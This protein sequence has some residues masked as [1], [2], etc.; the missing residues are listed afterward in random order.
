MSGLKIGNGVLQK[1]LVGK[2]AKSVTIPGDVE[3]VK[4]DAFDGYDN[5]RIVVPKL[6]ESELTWSVERCLC[7]RVEDH[8][9]WTKPY[10]EYEEGK[11][12]LAVW[13]VEPNM[14]ESAIHNAIK[15]EDCG[16]KDID[17][18]L[19]EVDADDVNKICEG[20]QAIG[21]GNLVDM[22]GDRVQTFK[23][24]PLIERTP[25]RQIGENSE[26]VNDIIDKEGS[27]IIWL[28]NLNENNCRN[29]PDNFIYNLVKHHSF[30]FVRL[31]PKW[32]VIVEVG[33]HVDL[34]V[35]GGV[36]AYFDG[37]NYRFKTPADYI[38]YMARQG[39]VVEPEPEPELKPEQS[40]NVLHPDG[41]SRKEIDWEE[42]HFQICLAL[43]TR[44]D[45][46]KT[47]PALII[48]RADEIVEALKKRAAESP[49]K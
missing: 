31:S 14:I 19:L 21:F 36:D 41:T 17:W 46:Y 5:L 6:M 39:K 37:N 12:C 8:D 47:T 20:M 3:R 4:A 35:S 42:R 2:D 15:S 25:V 27:G 32:L 34:D 30:N 22:Q 24:L 38:K 16:I 28:K 7:D 45:L 49:D 13:N 1:C 11:A 43:M 23:G 40:E 44:Q 9:N 33:K 10:L 29:L 18:S 48:K 26:Y